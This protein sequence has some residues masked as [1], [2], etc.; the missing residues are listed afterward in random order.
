MPHLESRS[1]R[2]LVL[3]LLPGLCGLM[4]VYTLVFAAPP[5][6]SAAETLFL[7]LLIG[8]AQPVTPTP[9]VTRSATP[10]ATRSATATPTP[11]PSP[12]PGGDVRTGRA[13]YYGATGA[14]N[15]SF[16]ATPEN[17]MVAAMNTIDYANAL[18]CGAFVEVTGPKGTIVVRIVDRCPE[19]GRGNIDL[20]QQAF[21]RIAD[22]SAGIVPITWRIVSPQLTGS[23]IYHFKEGSNQWWT[24]VQIRNH[25]NPIAKF[26][27]RTSQGQFK[28]VP[29]EDYNYFVE[30]SGMGPGP[31]TFRVT[32]IYGNA[33]TDS[34]IR[35]VENGDVSGATQFPP[36]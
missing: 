36:R 5:D 29:R 19:C 33:L 1:T 35:F 16:D 8:D 14:G 31:Y 34:S 10:T 30:T 26:E 4:F 28:A 23:I 7:P 9:T 15:C 21:E 12:T 11:T 18:L 3:F 13:T 25:R 22:L 6:S 27:Y 17:L 24:A 20:S 32:D 2:M